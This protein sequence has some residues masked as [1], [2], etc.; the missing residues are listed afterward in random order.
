MIQLTR[1]QEIDLA[2][3]IGKT[4]F[5]KTDEIKQELIDLYRSMLL[6]ENEWQARL[7]QSWGIENGAI[8]P[9]PKLPDHLL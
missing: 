6:R 8:V 1:S 2:I 7:R 4:D 9:A 3:F 5:K